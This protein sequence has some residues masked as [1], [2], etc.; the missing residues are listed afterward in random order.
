MFT[1]A[2]PLDRTLRKVLVWTAPKHGHSCASTIGRSAEHRHKD[3][4]GLLARQRLGS[5]FDPK[6]SRATESDTA[7]V[8]DM[9]KFFI[10][11]NQSFFFAHRKTAVEE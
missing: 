2:V 3:G 7:A 8:L 11:T 9:A 1:R 4:L 6:R 5:R 10:S